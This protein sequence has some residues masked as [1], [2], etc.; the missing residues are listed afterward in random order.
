MA[1]AAARALLEH[2]TFVDPKADPIVRC[3]EVLRT[4]T[5]PL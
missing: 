5:F 2:K 4:L 1:G 3:H